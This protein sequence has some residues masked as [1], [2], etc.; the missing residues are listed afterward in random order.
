MK[1]SVEDGRM[2]LEKV[3]DEKLLLESAIKEKTEE[4]NKI[5]SVL[6]KTT[7]ELSSL[8]FLR[9]SISSI[10]FELRIFDSEL[11][12]GFCSSVVFFNTDSILF[13]ENRV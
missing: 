13:R 3:K 11:F 2:N 1:K 12:L 8:V 10:I 6:K 4:L 7:E 5:E 9:C